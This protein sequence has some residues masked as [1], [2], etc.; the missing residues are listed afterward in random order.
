MCKRKVVVGFAKP[1]LAIKVSTTQGD[2]DKRR[3]LC[4]LLNV[5]VILGCYTGDLLPI[6]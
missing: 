2:W 4:L 6:I 1:I 3:K 5:E